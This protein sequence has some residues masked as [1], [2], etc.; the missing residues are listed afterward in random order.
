MMKTLVRTPF[1]GSF[2]SIYLPGHRLDVAEQTGHVENW[3]DDLAPLAEAG[4]TRVRYPLRWHRIEAGFCWFPS[5]DSCDWDSLLAR[6]ARRIDPVGVVSLAP[7]NTRVRTLFTDVWEAAAAGRPSAD[8]PA[9]RF[10]PPCDEQLG[11][12]MPQMA[13]WNW[14]DPPQNAA[15]R[16][17]VVTAINDDSAAVETA[18][19]YDPDDRTD[20]AGTPGDVEAG[21]CTASPLAQ[22]LESA[23][24][25]A[26]GAAIEG[27]QDAALGSLRLTGS[28]VPDLDA[29]AVSSATPFLR[30]PLLARLS[31][32]LLLHPPAGGDDGRCSSCDT[33]A[34]CDTAQALSR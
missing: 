7:D 20:L 28:A 24:R 18:C 25:R 26:I 14:Q 31:A 29:A 8:L 32:A 6:P 11:G 2:E 3:R 17:L 21:G 1:L 22:E 34:P 19:G 9:Y 4:V 15:V 33:P 30:A 23:Q 13:H 16:P 27:L 12:L 5:L 10:Q